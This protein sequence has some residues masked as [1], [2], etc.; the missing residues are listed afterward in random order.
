M[1][2]TLTPITSPT[3]SLVV[4]T[5]TYVN[6]ADA[7][8]YIDTLYDYAT[9]WAALDAEDQARAL[10]SATKDIDGLRLKGYKSDDAQALA[11]PRVLSTPYPQ[12]DHNR[13]THQATVPQAVIDACCCEAAALVSTSRDT[14]RADGVSEYAIGSL[15]EK[16][17]GG[18]RP[19]KSREAL[20]LLKPY[21]IGA[22]PIR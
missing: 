16:L 13:L 18:A 5:N 7:S 14:L 4:G 11:F 12:T 15:R 1:T 20:R 3:L 6:L 2:V 22:V 19:L 21:I 9:T 17:T 10:I 8:G